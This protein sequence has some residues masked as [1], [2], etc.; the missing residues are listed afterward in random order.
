MRDTNRDTSFDYVIPQ[1][2]LYDERS[3]SDYESSK[4]RNKQK[5]RDVGGDESPDA[6]QHDKFDPTEPANI[7]EEGDENFDRWVLYAD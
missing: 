7:P 1:N 5:S 3:Y 2:F 4:K 6:W